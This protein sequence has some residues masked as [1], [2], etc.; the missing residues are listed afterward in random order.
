MSAPENTVELADTM[1]YVIVRKGRHCKFRSLLYLQI[2]FEL[3]ASN[4]T[5]TLKTGLA[6]SGVSV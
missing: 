4:R 1:G 6:F 3:W 2:I 5:I